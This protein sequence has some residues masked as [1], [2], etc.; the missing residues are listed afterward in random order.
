MGIQIV[1]V[2]TH[3]GAGEANTLL[4]RI[5]LKIQSLIL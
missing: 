1:K 5:I 3:T 4:L 2:I